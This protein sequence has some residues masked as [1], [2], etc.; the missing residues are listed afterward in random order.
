MTSIHEEYALIESEIAALE[1]KK[2][3]L[4]T[5][6]LQQMVEK[7]QNKIETAV[8]SFTVSKLKKWSYPKWVTDLGDEFKSAKA[9]AES[10]EEATYEENESL[11]FTTLKL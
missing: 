3:Q 1:V 7:G 10:T 9:K 11:R 2:G 4:R 8:G 6:I 5:V